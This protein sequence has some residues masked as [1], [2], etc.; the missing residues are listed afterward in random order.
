MDSNEKRFDELF[1]CISPYLE[2]KK[3][4]KIKWQD[5]T[6]YLQYQ[7][8]L[9]NKFGATSEDWDSW[10]WQ[11]SHRLTD[12]QLI[13]DI[14]NLSDT[15]KQE[16][17]TVASNYRMALSPFLAAI[18]ASKES[19]LAR[20]FLPSTLEH[21]HLCDGE[22]DPMKEEETSPAP[23][24]TRRYPDRIIL[25]V[26][27]VCGSFCR[28]C[29]RRRNHGQIDE[30]INKTELE[31]SFD[32][33]RQHSE[34][35]DVLVTGGDPLTLSNGDLQYILNQ[36]RNIPSV[37]IIRI[38]TRMPVVIPQRVDQGLIEIIK[39]HAPIYINIHVNHPMEISP[40]MTKAC[41]QLLLSG[42][43]LGSQTVLLSGINDSPD[44]LR[45]LFQSLLEIGVKP[46]Y[47]FHAKNIVGTNHFRTSVSEGLDIIKSLRGNTS[48]LA[49]P[50]YVVNMPGGLGKVPLLPQNYIGSLE[51][52]P[53]LFR[54]WEDKIVPYPNEQ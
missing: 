17:D 19:P 13:A 36:L 31:L 30:H 54:T 6:S 4:M 42:A 50:T 21:E 12:S 43:V 47:L 38:G 9:L 10:K 41:R 11:M 18:L 46:Y 26:T 22:L 48:G 40:E 37:E 1:D 27:N 7:T 34:I 16:I 51:D 49:I 52:D 14:F 45:Y 2:A 39:N 5:S 25:N 53:I 33:I 29:Q 32:Y 28:F 20:Q 8:I 15:E 44:V 24:I 35:R 23:H 3:E